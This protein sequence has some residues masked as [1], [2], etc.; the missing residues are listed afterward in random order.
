VAR[1]TYRQ[2]RLIDQFSRELDEIERLWP[3]TGSYARIEPYVVPYI[4]SQRYYELIIYHIESKAWFDLAHYDGI[5][6]LLF[7]H[8]VIG[9]NDVVFDL[10]SNAGA[11]SIVLADMCKNG[12][13]VHA[14]DPY[15]WNAAATRY[16]CILNGLDNVKAYPVGLSNR[17]YTI[18]VAANESRI[19]VEDTTGQ[20]HQIVIHDFRRYSY[21]KPTFLKIDIEGSEHDL[22]Q[23]H[24]K[25][26]FESVKQFVLELHPFFIRP[27]GIDPK[28]T[29]K[30]IQASGFT[31]HFHSPVNHN[32]DVETFND[33]HHHLFW[34][35]RA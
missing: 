21:L 9:E 8:E 22:F 25:Q 12:G 29:L 11:I 32:F 18:D 5:I 17:D 30:A 2:Q 6:G 14:F 26:P 15:P 4:Q 34:G 19:F 16:N 20:A 3:M 23:D 24:D 7:Q 27:R 28:E 35:S 10:G 33:D 31:L 13:T 1:H